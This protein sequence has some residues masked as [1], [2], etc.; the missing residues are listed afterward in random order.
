MN[1]VQIILLISIVVVLLLLIDA[2]RRSKRKKY[3]KEMAALEAIQAQEKAKKLAEKEAQKTKKTYQADQV[4]KV[5][6]SA[7][8]KV[9]P[10]S[11]E[12]VES[13]EEATTTFPALEQGYAV[14][15]LSAPRGYVIPGA[16][17][18]QIFRTHKLQFDSKG[19]S[20]QR[21][22]D[23]KDPLYNILPDSKA[24]KFTQKELSAQDFQA[25]TCVMNLNRLAKYY[26]LNVCYQLFYQEIEKLNAALGATLLNEHKRRF[27]SH[28]ESAYKSQIKQFSSKNT[29]T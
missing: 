10:A 22:T 4:A 21:L 11:N 19:G 6:F 3:K 18:E 25:L 8:I 27:T 24:T 28:D 1:K 12:S 2:F 20:F 5:E 26:D 16:D 29:A 14:L 13:F 7:D 9:D 15:Y 17:L 23:D